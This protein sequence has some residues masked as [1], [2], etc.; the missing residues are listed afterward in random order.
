VYH[1]V[2]LDFHSQ[3]SEVYVDKIRT[4]FL[5]WTS[6]IK[7]YKS[8]TTAKSPF[9]WE[10]NSQSCLNAVSEIITKDGY[11]KKLSLLWSQESNRNG[12]ATELRP[13]NASYIKSLGPFDFVC[14]GQN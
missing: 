4:G 11:F 2:F 3:I 5:T 1:A 14:I 7:G 6:A 8:V 12:G 10:S 13:D 9:S